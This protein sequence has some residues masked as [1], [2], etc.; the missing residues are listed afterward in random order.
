MIAGA[1]G[2]TLA[3]VA[4]TLPA[5]STGLIYPDTRVLGIDVAGLSRDECETLLRQAFASLETHAVTFTFEDQSW[6]ASLEDLG[7]T[8]D[9]H[10]MVDA[11]FAHG[12]S[13]NPVTRYAT[14]ASQ[15]DVADIPLVLTANDL[16]R[17]RYLD[18]LHEQIA[19]E[20]VNA[21]LAR[22]GTTVE[23]RPEKLGRALDLDA[24]REQTTRAVATG[25][26]IEVPLP[27]I[28]VEPELYADQLEAAREDA[29][30]LIA[31]PIVFTHD[32]TSYDFDSNELSG[33]L[34]IAPD[35]SAS[36]DP[37][38]LQERMQAIADHASIPAQNVTLGWDGGLYVIEED[39]D[40]L[41]VDMEEFAARI[42]AAARSTDQRTVE[43]PTEVVRA[44][45]RADNL[46]EL[47]IEAHLAYGTSLYTGSN[48]T[49]VANVIVAADNISHK[50]VGP[51]ETF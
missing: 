13:A 11:A 2:T 10:A 24:A 15:G 30:V 16:V 46:D 28:E 47:G 42:Q 36:L 40:G 29:V 6:Q 27:T 49:R 8:I 34:A 14:L 44:A 23:I 3:G 9:Y 19:V 12:R 39:V 22:R 4:I 51:G 48:A 32:G 38:R 41:G 21:Q 37:E 20:P 1:L 26:A 7:M 33:A 45:A 35:G 50:M 17:D 18:T 43:L 31:D 25:R 5:R